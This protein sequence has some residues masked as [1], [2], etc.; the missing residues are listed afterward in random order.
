M[1]E[2]KNFTDTLESICIEVGNLNNYFRN[3]GNGN[4]K[5]RKKY[6]YEKLS[7]L[8]GEL[9]IATLQIIDSEGFTLDIYNKYCLEAIKKVLW[10]SNILEGG[11]PGVHVPFTLFTVEGLFE[12]NE[13]IVIGMEYKHKKAGEI[14]NNV[15]D[16]VFDNKDSIRNTAIT[17]IS[18][19]CATKTFMKTKPNPIIDNTPLIA[20]AITEIASV[21]LKAVQSQG[22]SLL[23]DGPSAAA[24]ITTDFSDLFK[25]SSKTKIDFSEAKMINIIE[26][27]IFSF[28][29]AKLGNDIY[30]KYK[31]ISKEKSKSV[32]E[33]YG[34]NNYLVK[35]EQVTSK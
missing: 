31:T 22:T 19:Y 18:L 29:A 33:L 5:K 25:S 27:I 9:T 30:N 23:F 11:K 24:S 12:E 13:T 17:G 21:S 15:V 4:I 34:L 7:N 14:I 16:A 6:C 10:L 1:F 35:C 32:N 8:A 2:C 20:K 28:I 3:E 26:F